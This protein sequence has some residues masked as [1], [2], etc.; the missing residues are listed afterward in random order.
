MPISVRC[1]RKIFICQHCHGAPGMVTTFADAPFDGPGLAELL[2][3][4][5]S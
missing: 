3:A 1:G 5:A 4:G 2:I